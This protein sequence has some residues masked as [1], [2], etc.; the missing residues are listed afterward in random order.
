MHRKITAA[1]YDENYYQFL[2]QNRETKRVWTRDRAA[3]LRALLGDREEQRVL[4]LGCGIGMAASE[5][6]ACGAKVVGLDYSVTAVDMASALCHEYGTREVHLIVGDCS[7]IPLA[8]AVFDAVLC[9]DLVEH[10]YEAK[11]LTMLGEA[12]RVLKPGG[13]LMVYTPSPTHLFEKLRRF[14]PS[15]VHQGAAVV[16][17]GDPANVVGVIVNDISGQ[18]LVTYNGFGPTTDTTVYLPLIMSHQRGSDW[19]TTWT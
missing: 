5:C 12:H 3:N 10:L 9:A 1:D 14:V 6:T 13:Q 17:T 4:D 7:S 8:D 15:K 11:F 19:V 16:D 2:V 18:R